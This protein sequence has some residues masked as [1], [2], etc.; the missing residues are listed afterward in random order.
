MKLVAEWIWQKEKELLVNTCVLTRKS[1]ILD[2]I[3]QT[4][5]IAISADTRY[6]LYVNGKWVNDGPIRSFPWQYSYD[7]IDV[8]QYLRVGTNV[9]AVSVNHWGEATYQSLVAKGGLLVQLEFRVKRKKIVIVSDES[10]QMFSCPCYDI[11]SPRASCHLGFEEHYDSRNLE[12]DWTAIDFDSSEWQQALIVCNS[13]GGAWKKLSRRGI[14]LLATDKVMPKRLVSESNVKLPKLTRTFRLKRL[15]GD[16]HLAGNYPSFKGIIF[17]SIVS[18]SNQIVQIYKPVDGLMFGIVKINNT[19]VDYSKDFANTDRLK[20][21]LRHGINLVAIIFDFQHHQ[22]EFQL[23]IDSKQALSIKNVFGK[24]ECVVAGPF[25]SDDANWLKMK[26]I[27]HVEEFCNF[28][29]NFRLPGSQGISHVDVHAQTCLQERRM[30]EPLLEAVEAMLSENEECTILRKGVDHE[31]VLDFGCEFNMYVGFEIAAPKG[32]TID[33]NIFERY[34]DCKPQWTM[35]NRSGFR[36]ISKQG[37]QSFVSNRN[38]GGRY[39]SI[40]FRNISS[41][42]KIKNIFGLFK[43]YPVNERGMFSCDDATLNQ[44]WNVSKQTLLCCM[45]DTFTDCPAYEQ[46]YWIG[47]GRIESLIFQAIFGADSLIKRCIELPAQC[48]TRS[49]LIESQAPTGLP[50]IIPVWSFLWI[51]MSKEYLDATGDK[52]LLKKIFHAISK[53]LNMCLQKYVDQKTGLFKIQAW[54]FFDWTGIDA[55][56]S[57]VTHNNIFFVEALRDASIVANELGYQDKSNIWLKKAEELTK[58]INKFCWSDERGA[59]IDSIHDDGVQSQSVSRPVNTVALLYDIAPASRARKIL[60]IVN[61]ELT[62]SIVPFGSPFAIQFFLEF[63]AKQNNIKLMLE[64]IR[65]Y[66][67]RMLDYDTTTFWESFGDIFGSEFPSRSYCHAWSAGPV[68][69]LSRYVIGVQIVNIT[70]KI[71]KIR[72][73]ILLLKRLKGVAPTIMGDFNVSWSHN[74]NVLT[75]GLYV[76]QKVAAE[77]ELPNE[78]KISEVVCNGKAMPIAKRKFKLIDGIVNELKIALVD[79]V[80]P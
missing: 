18:D 55:H 50:G 60:P 5:L 20:F 27:R 19:T 25:E 11:M 62:D 56:A 41:D 6:R 46:A 40:T 75:I 80:I 2:T 7:L 65:S 78:I 70:A 48:L 44:I 57:R 63:L 42:I 30:G 76:P 8:S 68:Y 10:W 16:E 54:N 67:G 51:K 36:Y 59:Y 47:D 69:L 34:L 72:P 38:F 13:T 77:L 22:H 17:F 26:Q 12:G 15:F 73:Q 39:L 37:W 53:M 9:L 74:S 33:F 1:F 45:E 52:I 31:I 43:H 24:G 49:D 64:T 14:P 32:V 3:P 28:K 66:W 61:G 21:K 4:A 23:I 58:S 71:V 79:E 35:H 29:E